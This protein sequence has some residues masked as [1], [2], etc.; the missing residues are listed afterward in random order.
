[1]GKRSEL[2]R[3]T[4]DGLRELVLE[5][6]ARRR[7]VADALG[8]SF[9]K[10]KALRRLVGGPYSMRE[11]AAKLSTDAPYTTLLLDDLEERGLVLR[12]PHPDDRRAMLVSLTLKGREAAK[13]AQR[14]L[15]EPPAA[16]RGLEPDDLAELHRLVRKLTAD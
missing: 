8:M 3:E 14:I 7:E 2:E 4:W 12:E 13:L 16:L 5:R 1:M 15:D 9:L 11:L 6:Y 10:A